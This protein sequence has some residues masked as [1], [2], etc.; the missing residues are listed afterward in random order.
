M[1]ASP[2]VAPLL[3]LQVDKAV[4]FAPHYSLHLKVDLA[5]GLLHLPTLPAFPGPSG[6][7]AIP[8]DSASQGKH[9]IYAPETGVAPPGNGNTMDLSVPSP[10]PPGLLDRGSSDVEHRHHS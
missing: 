4:P 9:S 8:D 10:P 5:Q 6:P 7:Y 3:H 1:L 2:S